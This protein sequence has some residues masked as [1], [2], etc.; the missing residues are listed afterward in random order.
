[1][2]RGQNPK[3]LENLEKTTR[4]GRTKRYGDR[5]SREVLVSEE[6]WQ[7]S[8]TVAK[9]AGYSG[10]SEMLEKLGRGDALLMAEGDRPVLPPPPPPVAPVD[11]FAPRLDKLIETTL[12]QISPRDRREAGKLLNRLRQNM[13]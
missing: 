6:G 13:S 9:A 3:S 1:M 7:G 8:L 10:V 12:M 11:D 5:K 2:P 4:P